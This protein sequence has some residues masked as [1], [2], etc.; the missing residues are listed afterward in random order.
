MIH[1]GEKCQHPVLDQQKRAKLCPN[2]AAVE[3]RVDGTDMTYCAEHATVM[4]A[5]TDFTI[6]EVPQPEPPPPTVKRPRRTRRKGG[7]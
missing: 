7:A 3:L 1:P 6:E 4:R 5:R 2:A